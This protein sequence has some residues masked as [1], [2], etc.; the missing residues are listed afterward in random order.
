MTSIQP[1][2]SSACVSAVRAG[3]R[4]DAGSTMATDLARRPPDLAIARLTVVT[5]PRS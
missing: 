3:A 5:S 4:T 2:T 1:N